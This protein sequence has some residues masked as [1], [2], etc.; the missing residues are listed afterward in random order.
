MKHS[1]PCVITVNGLNEASMQ[2]ICLYGFFV[3]E[4]LESLG[5]VSALHRSDT[6]YRYHNTV[7]RQL[8]YVGKNAYS[9]AGMHSKS[10]TYNDAAYVG[11]K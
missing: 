8:L 10:V 6:Q 2:I 9:D 1:V 5:I 11:S 3:F 7:F 4:L